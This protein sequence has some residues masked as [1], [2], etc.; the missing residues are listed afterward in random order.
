MGYDRSAGLKPGKYAGEMS[1]S[2]SGKI[3]VMVFFV[4]QISDRWKA[5]TTAPAKESIEMAEEWLVKQAAKYGKTVS[6]C[7]TYFGDETE[8]PLLVKNFQQH[9]VAFDYY[10]NRK[11]LLK[12]QKKRGMDNWEAYKQFV[13]EEMGCEQGIMLFVYIKPDISYA[14]WPDNMYN[15]RFSSAVCHKGDNAGAYI[16]EMLHLFGAWDM[17]K[18]YYDKGIFRNFKCSLYFSKS[19]MRNTSYWPIK[20]I[21]E[22]NAWLVGLK[23]EEKPWYYLF[24]PECEE[25]TELLKKLVLYKDWRTGEYSDKPVDPKPEPVKPVIIEKKKPSPLK[26]WQ[27]VIGWIKNLKNYLS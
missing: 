5:N 1:K 25:K 8:K 11:E 22:I 3:H 17:Y 19:I 21:D 12:I 16:H 13:K 9:S 20:E 15:Y 27:K 18:R 2:L 4:S 10:S 6:F 14:L 23:D 24:F 26:G 7:N